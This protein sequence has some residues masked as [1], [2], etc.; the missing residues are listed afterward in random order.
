MQ[1]GWK[2]LNIHEC[3]DEYAYKETTTYINNETN[4]HS[5]DVLAHTHISIIIC[6]VTQ[7]AL[8]TMDSGLVKLWTVLMKEAKHN[9]STNCTGNF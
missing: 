7:K 2:P 6:L 1:K 9:V 8:S 3:S 4:K 5:T